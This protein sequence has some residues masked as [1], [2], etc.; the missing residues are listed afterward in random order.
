ML[1]KSVSWD[2]H[3]HDERYYTETEV[4]NLLVTKANSNHSHSD[5]A[6]TTTVNTLATR[7]SNLEG[8]VDMAKLVYAKYIYASNYAAGTVTY[9]ASFVR[10]K[11]AR[12]S[13][14]SAGS[15]TADSCGTAYID[16]PLGGSGCINIDD[17]CAIFTYSTDGTVTLAEAK[18]FGVTYEFYNY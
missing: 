13:S 18:K 2:G 5:Y 16:I 11:I 6:T 9:K 8:S 15:N 7:V 3:I 14:A 17:N 4:N 10:V 1:G 12:Y